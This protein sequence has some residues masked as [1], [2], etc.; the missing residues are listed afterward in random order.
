MAPRNHV[1]ELLCGIWAEVLGVKQVGIRDTFFEL[2]GHSI[3]AVQMV[4]RVR[5]VFHIAVTVGTV[6]VKNTVEL[7]S[8]AVEEGLSRR[9]ETGNVQIT[10]LNRSSYRLKSEI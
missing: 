6:F 1:E 5:E 4:A 2:G 3:L 10:P 7:F 8:Q 9:N